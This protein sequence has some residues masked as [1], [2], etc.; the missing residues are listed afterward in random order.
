MPHIVDDREKR[1]RWRMS[2]RRCAARKESPPAPENTAETILL[3]GNRLQRRIF[4][5]SAVIVAATAILVAAVISAQRTSALERTKF[6][7][8]NLSAAFQEQISQVI[9]TLS[10]A[11]DRFRSRIE[12]TSA[13]DAIRDGAYLSDLGAVSSQLIV[14]GSDGKVEATSLGDSFKGIDLADREHFKAHLGNRQKGAFIGK[15]VLGRLS[16]RMTIPLSMRLEKPNGRFAGVL[17]ATLDTDFLMGFSRSVDLGETGSLL[18]LGTDGVVRAFYSRSGDNNV[19][20]NLVGSTL[21]NLPA[22]RD[23]EFDAEGTYESPGVVD[24]VVRVHHWRKVRGYPLLIV[25]GLGKSEALTASNV[26][27]R[28]VLGVGSAAFLLAL[29]MPLMLYREISKRIA[30]EI[31]LNKERLKLKRANEALADERRNLSAINQELIAEKRRAEDASNAKSAFL[32]NMSHEFRTPMH[33]ILNYTSMGLKRLQMDDR[34]KLGKYL[35]NTRASGL[36]LLSMLNGLLD[37]AKLES[38]K[39]DLYIAKSDLMLIIEETQVEIGSLLDEKQL[40]IAMHRRTSDTFA[41]FDASRMMQVLVNLLSNAIKFSPKGGLIEVVVSDCV[42]ANGAPGLQ[43]SLLDEGVGIPNE[44]LCR[45]FDRFSQSS[46]TKR[47]VTGSGLGLTICRELIDL[48]GGIIWAE[49][50][51]E[52]GACFSFIIPKEM[53]STS[54]PQH[55]VGG[56]IALPLPIR[57]SARIM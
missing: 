56:G 1:T 17:I 50:R 10:G 45:I 3:S 5:F 48:H 20:A 34:E 42:L 13:A 57:S 15:P 19:S 55:P 26:Q 38:G 40:R 11:M 36:R 21:S 53:A 9:S 33:A 4:V 29:F 14:T 12:Q 49:N 41:M 54:R 51:E 16:G 28:M 25:V 44:E 8:S 22:L 37:L 32:M 47:N 7:A 35:S 23:A 18:L 2:F 31:D 30:N 24:K 46:A 27:G 6:D 39:L 43:C 52:G